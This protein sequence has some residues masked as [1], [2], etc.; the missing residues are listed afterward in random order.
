MGAIH[1]RACFFRLEILHPWHTATGA[2]HHTTH[3]AHH[4][5][6]SAFFCEL[7]HHFLHLFVL[8]EQSVDILDLGSGAVGNTLLA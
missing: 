5:G 7:F 2:L 6:N 1:C 8:L 3:T 4:V